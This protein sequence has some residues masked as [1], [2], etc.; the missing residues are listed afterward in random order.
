MA[1]Y[2]LDRDAAV[3]RIGRCIEKEL[4]ALAV[5]REIRIRANNLALQRIL[6][7]ALP[8]DEEKISMRDLP[9]AFRYVTYR[10]DE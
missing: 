9:R 3:T 7:I 10:A 2:I 4:K 8:V 6:V 1:E 5:P